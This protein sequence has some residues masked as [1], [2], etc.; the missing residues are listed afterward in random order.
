MG[1]NIEQYSY[2]RDG[3]YHR[4]ENTLDIV[5]TYC[6]YYNAKDHN[7]VLGTDRYMT[8][9]VHKVE[10]RQSYA[11]LVYSCWKTIEDVDIDYK[12]G[13]QPNRTNV[14]ECLLDRGRKLDSLEF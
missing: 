11:R 2:V 12:D 3:E 8:Y 14:L 5:A 4:K 9:T 13:H 7:M 6:Y 1:L 10:V